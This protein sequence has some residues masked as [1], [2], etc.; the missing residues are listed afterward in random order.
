MP[1]GHILSRLECFRSNLAGVQVVINW[2]LPQLATRY[3]PFCSA[4]PT[5]H[6]RRAIANCFPFHGWL[7]LDANHP[8]GQQGARGHALQLPFSPP[9]L[10][11]SV[12]PASG[13]G[14]VVLPVLWQLVKPL[15]KWPLEEAKL[16]T[17]E[18]E[19]I[20][21]LL[22]FEWMDIGWELYGG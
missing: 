13:R 18:A 14:L 16:F 6:V 15:P 1:T 11:S 12:L 4:L 7:L 21:L 19:W 22:P 9:E 2:E 3:F 5:L 8:L 20:M 10:C 17:G